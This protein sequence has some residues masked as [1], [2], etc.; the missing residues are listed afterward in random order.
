MLSRQKPFMLHGYL[1]PTRRK[2]QKKNSHFGSWHHMFVVW[3]SFYLEMHSSWNNLFIAF[4]RFWKWH[5]C[6]C[7][8]PLPPFPP[9]A[10]MTGDLNQH[11]CK[12]QVLPFN[13][14]HVALHLWS[15]KYAVKQ[16][17]S[18]FST[19]QYG[20]QGRLGCIAAEIC[21]E[22]FKRTQDNTRKCFRL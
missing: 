10:T 17:R 7:S 21:C 9:V 6:F 12:S 19:S 4:H 14:L 18:L 5:W 15:D 1:F 16:N 8:S 22:L 3:P 20:W 2:K 11:Y 13:F